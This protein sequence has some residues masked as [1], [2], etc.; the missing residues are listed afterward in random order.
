MGLDFLYLMFRSSSF[1]WVM[2]VIPIEI[3]QKHLKKSFGWYLQLKNNR[4][5][6]IYVHFDIFDR[7][8]EIV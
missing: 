3:Q 4:L 8:L 1:L 2:P 6:V 7:K 5:K